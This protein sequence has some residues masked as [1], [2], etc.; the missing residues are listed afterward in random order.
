MDP[1]EY[2]DLT[3]SLMQYGGIS[4][5]VTI[6]AIGWHEWWGSSGR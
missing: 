4:G 2:I 6:A 5:I 1:A 3:I